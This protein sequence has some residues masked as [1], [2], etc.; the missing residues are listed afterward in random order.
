MEADI[1]ISHDSN[2]DLC[3]ICRQRSNENLNIV[4]PDGI[5]TLIQSCE[6]R[7]NTQVQNYIQSCTA[8]VLVHHSCRKSF[9][10]LRKLKRS[11]IEEEACSS[12]SRSLRSSI[13]SF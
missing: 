7:G 10:D 8:S 11:K 3:V 5:Q 2:Y 13:D 4:R 12:V 9:N 6:A 1:N